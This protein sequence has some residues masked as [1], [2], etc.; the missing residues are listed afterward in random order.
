MAPGVEVK[1]NGRVLARVDDLNA[2]QE[3]WKRSAEGLLLLK[4]RH[5]ERPVKLNVAGK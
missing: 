4:L 1:A 3:G 2:A 5:D